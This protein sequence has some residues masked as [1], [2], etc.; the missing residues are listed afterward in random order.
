MNKDKLRQMSFDLQ[1]RLVDIRRDFHMHP[2][3]GEKEFETSKRVEEYLAGIGIPHQRIGSST[4]VLGL[5]KGKEGGKTVAVRADMDALPINEENDFPFKSKNS[6]FMHACG[7]DAHMTILLG[8]AKI[9][10]SLKSEFS[11]NIKLLF[12]PAE[13]ADGGAKKMVEAGCLENPHVDCC[14]GLHVQ[15]YI[16]TGKIE[17]KYGILNASSDRLVITVKGKEAHGAYPQLGTDAV[18]IAAN[19]ITALQ[20]VISRSVAPLDNAVLTIGKISGGVKENI[21]A[22]SVRMDATVRTVNPETREFVLKKIKEITTG[23]S[24][25]MG[26]FAQVEIIRGYDPLINDSGV[27]DVIKKSAEMLLG[28]DNVIIKDKPSLGAE[29]F[30]FFLNACRGAF[31]HLGCGY[32]SGEISSR[33]HSSTFNLDENCLALGVFLQS[34]LALKFLGEDLQ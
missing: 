9:L 31:Y 2:E 16:P 14:I 6:G 26:G 34:Y 27:C 8:A 20:S 29:D 11:G 10:N 18:V 17:L 24:S 15:P 25:A 23:V 4:A 28:G 21:I 13:E 19:V 33:L 30:S 12:Q 3:I 1:P 7:H 22:G 32:P 5:I